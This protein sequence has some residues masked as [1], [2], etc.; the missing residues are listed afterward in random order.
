MYLICASSPVTYNG[1]SYGFP[2]L[3]RIEAEGMQTIPLGGI[4]TIS[5]ARGGNDTLFNQWNQPLN[6]DVRLSIESIIDGFA[7]GIG[8]DG[9]KDNFYGDQSSAA[10]GTGARKS[11]ITN[12]QDIVDSFTYLT[13]NLDHVKE[14]SVK[15]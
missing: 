4:S 1:T 6:V 13:N 3:W 2:P 10:L 11:L 15:L 8:P 5:I 14:I 7:V 12:P 9:S